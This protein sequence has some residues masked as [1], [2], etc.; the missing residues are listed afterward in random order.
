MGVIADVNNITELDTL[1]IEQTDGNYV[2][3]AYNTGLGI[4]DVSWTGDSVNDSTCG[5]EIL[6]AGGAPS[7]VLP[8][9]PAI[10]SRI[11]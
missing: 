5:F 4:V 3:M 2:N 7:I 9:V 10:H 11:R 8:Y 1:I 6:N